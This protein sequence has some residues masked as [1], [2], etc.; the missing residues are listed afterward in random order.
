MKIRVARDGNKLKAA[1]TE[2]LTQIQKLKE[3]EM[4]LIKVQRIRNPKLHRKYFA[5]I[6]KVYENQS[7]FKEQEQLR[8]FLE[9]A[10]GHYEKCYLPNRLTGEIVEQF[11]PKSI[12]Y[13]QLDGDGFQ[14]LYEKVMD[15]VIRNFDFDPELLEQELRGA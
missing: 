1:K 8:K 5:L 6:R 4:V 9:M 7:F 14:K 11:W 3:G 15:E 2:D 13:S 12:A 10:A